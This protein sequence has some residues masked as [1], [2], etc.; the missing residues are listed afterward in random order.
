MLN[1][2]L[3][4]P[5]FLLLTPTYLL[6][7]VEDDPMP[8]GI[9]GPAVMCERNDSAATFTSADRD[10]SHLSCT[11]TGA[12]NTVV[13]SSVPGTGATALG[14]AEDAAHASG[15]TGVAAWSVRTDTAASSAGTT[16]DYA[17][18]A[19][20]ALGKLWVTGTYLEDAAHASAD[21]GIQVLARILTGSFVPSSATNADYVTLNQDADGRLIVNSQGAAAGDTW[22][23]CTTSDITDT[24]NTAIKAANASA[25]HYVTS[26]TVS[27]LDDTTATRVLINDGTTRIWQCPAAINGGGCTLSFPVPLRGTSNTALNCQPITTGATVQCCAAGYESAN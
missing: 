10:A 20:D 19:T 11:S 21:A 13:L 14:K 16:G 7:Q 12:L 18:L 4:V 8:Q 27:N 15:D 9:T 22:S 3:L 6:A 1:K 5:L 17:A 25:R 26:I 24:T 23:A 2:K